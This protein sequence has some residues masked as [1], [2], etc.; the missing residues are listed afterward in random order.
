MN[1]LNSSPKCYFIF[2]PLLDQSVVITRY[3]LTYKNYINIVGVVIQNEKQISH[4]SGIDKI[5][6]SDSLKN[7]DIKR[8]LIPTGAASTKYCL[9]TYGDICLGEVTLKKS[10]L[11]VFDKP[12]LID[13]ADKIGIPVPRT[14]SNIKCIEAYPVFYKQRFEQGCGDRGIAEL[15]KDIPISD[16]LIFQEIIHSKGTYGVAFLANHG[17][18]LVTHT[19]FERESIPLVGGSAVIIESFNDNRLIDYTGKLIKSLDYS[20]WGLAEYK[21]CHKRNDYVLMEINAK[22]WASCELAFLNEPGFI[23]LLFDIDAKKKSVKRIVFIERAFQRGLFFF[24]KK[25]FFFSKSDL[26]VYQGGYFR[27]IARL[28]FYYFRIVLRRNTLYFSV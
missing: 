10:A 17:E 7:I 9:E 13:Y 11:R 15:E 20:G 2:S 6:N 8:N 16:A 25:L 23:K 28:L 21:Y 4:V 5:I 27:I 26:R 1:T 22:F 14:W 19:H 24:I 18:L 3:L 12:W